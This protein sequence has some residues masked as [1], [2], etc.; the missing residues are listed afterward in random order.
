MGPAASF[1]EGERGQTNASVGL[2]ELRSLS[3]KLLVF[4]A[5]SRVILATASTALGAEVP[6]N[7]LPKIVIAKRPRKVLPWAG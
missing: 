7:A 6:T 4:C 2:R 5:T 1:R 3:F